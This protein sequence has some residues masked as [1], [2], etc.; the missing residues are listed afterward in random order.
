MRCGRR[1][2]CVRWR[3]S[4][5]IICE[6]RSIVLIGTDESHAHDL[7]I[8]VEGLLRVFAADHSVILCECQ[9]QVSNVLD[10][11]LRVH[12]HSVG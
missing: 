5:E 9:Q 1:W 10:Y 2:D 3:V 8:K 4:K 6:F 11:F 12:Y 7:L